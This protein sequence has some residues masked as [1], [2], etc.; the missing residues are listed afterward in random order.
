MARKKGS[1]TVFLSLTGILIFALIGT[2]VETAR[3][4]ACSNHA[5]RTLRLAAEGLL[6]EYSRPLYE[7]YGLFFLESEGTPFETVISKYA[8]DTFSAAKKGY[9]DF[10]RGQIQGVQIADKVYLGDNQAAALQKEINYYMTRKITKEQLEK[11]LKKSEKVLQTEKQAKEIEETVEEEREAAEMDKQ[12]LELMRL[13]DG[14][15]VSDG[16][17]RCEDEF[18]KMFAT[19]EIKGQNFSITE[20]KVWEKMKEKIDDTPATWEKAGKSEFLMRVQKVRKLV[21]QAQEQASLLRAGYQK[22]G[23]KSREF[24]EHDR[25][26]RKLIDSLSVLSVNQ[27]ILEETERK[28]KQGLNE[29]TMGQLR[30]LWEDYDTTSIVFDYAGVEETGGGENPLDVLSS[31]WGDGILSLVCETPDKISKKNVADSDNFAK[32]YKEQPGETEDYDSRI[33]EFTKD[34]EVSLSGVVGDAGKYVLEEFCLDSYIQ[35]KFGSYTAKVPDWKKS[36]EYQWEYVVAGGDSDK[37]NL[38][39]VLNRIL[40]IRAVANFAAIYRDSGKKA[41]AYTAAAAIVGFTGLEPLI[42]LTQTI[43]LI[44]WSIVEGLVDLAG[45]LQGRDVPVVK[46]PS[47]VLTSFSQLFQISG[48]TITGRA[49]K[50]KKA[51]KDSFGYREYILLFM[52]FTKKSTR[53]YRVM[54]MIQWDMVKNGYPDFHLGTCVFSVTV[55]GEFSF[56]AYFFRMVPIGKMLERDFRTYHI[57]CRITESYL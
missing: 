33:S 29:E 54:D 43:I 19:G 46:S 32:V 27:K 52:A 55:Q 12:F 34:E 57:S 38:S 18:I 2:L 15:S 36:L 35:D 40:L 10:F 48:K 16:G 41:E 23:G 22:F 30:E 20:N 53:L 39:S 25:K 6:T 56:P 50:W 4:T 1:I 44:V 51:G 28:L 9:M 26:M 21:E 8:G 5:A 42:R 7:H 47:G 24:D 14:I 31:V 49:K 3:Y 17:I 11:F 45:L 13:V 37:K